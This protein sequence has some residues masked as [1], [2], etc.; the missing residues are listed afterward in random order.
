M[1]YNSK[2]YQIFKFKTYL[3]EKDFLIFHCAKINLKQW[4][5]V[6]QHL[7]KLRLQYYKPLNGVSLK[8]LNNSTHHHFGYLIS[9]PILFIEFE[10][11]IVLNDLSIILKQLEPE[12]SLISI[13][14]NNSIYM[15]K[16]CSGHLKTLNYNVNHG[17]FCRLMDSFLSAPF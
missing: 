14:L 1:D 11:K 2:K 16:S 3:K 13:K 6:E 10:Y 4:I 5:I 9:G 8:I 12:F 7:K 17:N 15:K